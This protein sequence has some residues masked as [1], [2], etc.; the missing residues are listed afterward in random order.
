MR[1]RFR[2][3]FMIIDFPMNGEHGDVIL[4]AER[5]RRICQRCCR[6]RASQHILNPVK[7]EETS[8]LILGFDHAICD[9]Q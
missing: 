7:S 9:K 3:V 5:L 1:F 2:S 6:P 8:M 4:L